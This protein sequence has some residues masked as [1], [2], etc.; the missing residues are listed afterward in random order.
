LYEIKIE[1]TGRIVVAL[2]LLFVMNLIMACF[3]LDCPEASHYYLK[4]ITTQPIDVKVNANQNDSYLE[5]ITTD[6][7]RN[8]LAFQTSSHVEFAALEKSNSQFHGFMNVAYGCI[9][10]VLLNPIDIS[11][12]SFSTN[13]PIYIRD[14]RGI[15]GL[16]DSITA[17][18]NLL[19]HPKIQ[20]QV[21]FPTD[22]SL[23]E[24][25]VTQIQINENLVFPQ[26]D[27]EFY[28]KWETSDGIELSDTVQVYL[29]F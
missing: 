20:A 13:R 29:M 24:D 26:G 17:H 2:S 10:N 6:T 25:A 15:A 27:Y 3:A 18:S 4:D 5:T 28:F 14:E 21:D 8:Q 1:M 23:E 7:L 9:E 16:A 22:L 11:K 12:S 19:D